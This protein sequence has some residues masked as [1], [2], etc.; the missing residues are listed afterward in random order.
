MVLALLSIV[1]L[2]QL[3]ILF[4]RQMLAASRQTP[5]A[6]S[7][8]TSWL[9]RRLP[10]RR[11]P[12]PSTPGAV[13][14]DTV[15]ADATRIAQMHHRI[16]SLF[17]QAFHDHFAFSLA[18][19]AA[20]TPSTSNGSAPSD[21]IDMMRAMSREIDMMFEDAL[22]DAQGRHLGFDEGWSDLAITPGMSVKDTNNAYEIT[23]ALPSADKSDIHLGMDGTILTLRVE[24]RETRDA[25]KD[26]NAAT[27]HQS[28]RVSRF[29]QRL[30]LPGADPNPAA[31]NA[32]FKDGVLRIVVPKRQESEYESGFIKVI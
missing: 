8:I 31:I 18:P 3:A 16:N 27:L 2:L 13:T 26:A 17:E 25:S 9:D 11:Q 24:H 6:S 32:S 19:A 22:N 28:R 10:W 12:V 30:K 21:P 23:V 5:P 7:A 15:W 4:Q 1:I 14:P 20:S 29:E